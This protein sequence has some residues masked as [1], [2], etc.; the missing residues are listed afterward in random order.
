VLGLVGIVMFVAVGQPQGGT[1]HPDATA[2]W[3]AGVATTIGILAL[4]VVARRRRGP[5]AATLFAT[6]AGLAFAFQAAVTKVFVDDLGDGLV[7]V[8]TTWTTYALIVSALLGFAL[9]QSALKTGF[10]APAMAASNASTLVV[11]V[12]LGITVFDET[13]DKGGGRISPSIIGLVIAAAGVVLLA[14]TD[15]SA[16]RIRATAGSV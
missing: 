9:Q 13:L 4:G 14:G 15:E 6:A 8:L 10:L 3:I 16:D 7:G 5:L 1:E 11:T 2:W 12:V